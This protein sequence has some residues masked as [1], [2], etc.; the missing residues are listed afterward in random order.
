MICKVSNS[1]EKVYQ[2]DLCFLEE[3]ENIVVNPSEEREVIFDLILETGNQEFYAQMTDEEIIKSSYFDI[4][5]LEIPNMRLENIVYPPQIKYGDSGELTFDLSTDSPA[6]NLV[7]KINKKELFTF[8]TYAGK[9][10]F[11]LPF[12]GKFF[13]KKDSKL[14]FEYEDDNGRRYTEEQEL[15]INVTN[16]PFYIVIGYWWALPVA[17]VLLFFLI[18]RKFSKT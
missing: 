18:K 13:Y 1:E 6:K 9:E 12:N 4:N 11:I 16:A 3:C 15:N 2:F 14:I 17:L 8:D 10:N 5:V 7:I